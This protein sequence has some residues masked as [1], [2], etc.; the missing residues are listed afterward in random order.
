MIDNLRYIRQLNVFG[1]DGQEALANSKVLCIGAGGLGSLVCSYLTAAGVGSIGIVDNDK[2]ELS[3]LTR[4]ITYNEKNC[5]SSKVQ[6]LG[7]FLRNLNSCITIQEYEFFLNTENADDLISDYDLVIDCSDNYSTRYLISD[8]CS[9]F[10]KPLIS[11]SIDVFTGQV[12]V[13]LP[14]VCY[15][16]IF[17]D[18]KNDNKCSNGDVVGPAVGI[19]ASIQANEVIKF[20]TSLNMKSY[21]IQ[22]DSLNNKQSCLSILPDTSCINNHD[23]LL[24]SSENKIIEIAYHDLLTL[25]GKKKIKILDIS[26]QNDSI[27]NEL[28][29]SS[30]K[31]KTNEVAE[32]IKL[33]SKD[34]PI[35][36]IC[37][38]GVRS[39]VFAS[40]LAV[41]GYNSVYYSSANIFN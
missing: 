16:C 21:I 39:K 29:V 12:M 31:I 11:A 22:V 13:L 34:Q 25:Y 18:V 8:A 36:V 27:F 17:P 2:I 24:C 32:L 40:R 33:I 37:N 15:R 38:Y 20:I 23:D 30:V 7:S 5:L 3:N 4:Q 6:V 26:S 9:L 41:L 1:N 35:A 10:A 14:E 19:I 28:I